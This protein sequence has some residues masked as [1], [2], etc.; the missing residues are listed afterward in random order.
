MVTLVLVQLECD[1]ATDELGARL[2]RGRYCRQGA[3]EK[4]VGCTHAWHRRTWLQY[5][6]ERIGHTNNT[7]MTLEG[8]KGKG[9]AYL[10]GK[11]GDGA[12]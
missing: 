10:R 6:H 3:R 7:G 9:V 1:V 2:A 12:C 8:G 5:L 4:T 11:V